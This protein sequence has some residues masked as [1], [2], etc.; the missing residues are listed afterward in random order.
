MSNMQAHTDKA[1]SEDLINQK[2]D[3]TISDLLVKTGAGFCI[4]VV[5]STVLFKRRVWPV[6]FFSGAGVGAAYSTAN[7]LFSQTPDN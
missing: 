2:W 1:P 3:K 4:G 6:Y 5:A 7:K